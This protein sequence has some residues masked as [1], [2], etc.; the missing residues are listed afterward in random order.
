M[1][2]LMPRLVVSTAPDAALLLLHLWLGVGLLGVHGYEKLVGFAQM[3]PGFPD[4][5]HLGP[6]PSLLIAL[7]ADTVGGLLVAVGLFT[8]LSAGFI[9]ASVGVALLFV[10]HLNL[11]EV[12]GEVAYLYLGG[13][14]AL[15]LAGPGK[16]S[17]DYRRAKRS[18]PVA[19]P[20]RHAQGRRTAA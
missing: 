14:I 18:Q 13:Y 7:L 4:P 20:S 1:Q 8:R 9:V 2:K 16:Y 5:I 3:A 17:L 19:V 6:T 11:L 15:L 12:N 10:W